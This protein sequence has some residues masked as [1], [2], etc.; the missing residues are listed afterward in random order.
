M[1]VPVQR[2]AAGAR[3]FSLLGLVLLVTLVPRLGAVRFNA[4]PHGDVLLDGYLSRELMSPYRVFGKAGNVSRLLGAAEGTEIKGT[5][6]V[7]TQ[8]V[9]SLLIADLDLPA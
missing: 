4:W 3:T 1:S 2:T 5:F 9:P 6:V 8:A 7:Y